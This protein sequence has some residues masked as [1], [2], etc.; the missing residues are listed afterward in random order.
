M[1]K[2]VKIST[3]LFILVI[4]V[5]SIIMAIGTYGI[6]SLRSINRSL[7]TVYEDRVMPLNQLK[8]VSDSYAIDIADACHKI[9]GGNIFWK[10]GKKRIRKAMISINDNWQAY[11]LTYMEGDELRL[12]EEANKLMEISN[13]SVELLE[14]IV[15][16]EDAALLEKYTVED[17][18][19]KIDPITDKINDL[20]A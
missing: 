5:S 1:F 6:S 8:N 3:K 17:L 7:D 15:D 4:A 20:I 9:R 14:E 11:L 16:K 10:A 19:K 18:Y 2:H 12:A 13:Q